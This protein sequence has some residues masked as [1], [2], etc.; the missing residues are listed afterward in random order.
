[1]H[2]GNPTDIRIVDDINRTWR[3]F[4]AARRSVV[5]AEAP[6]LLTALGAPGQPGTTA[7]LLTSL[8]D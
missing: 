7:R 6:K 8:L 1:V 3:S 2:F 4:V 5:K